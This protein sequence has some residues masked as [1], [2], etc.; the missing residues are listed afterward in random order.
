MDSIKQAEKIKSDLENKGYKVVN[1]FGG[2]RFSKIV[3][4]K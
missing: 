4:G 3:M 2:M 1:T